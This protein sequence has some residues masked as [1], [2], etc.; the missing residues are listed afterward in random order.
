[1]DP[2]SLAIITGNFSQTMVKTTLYFS[3]SLAIITGNFNQT[4]WVRMK[5]ALL[6][7]LIEWRDSDLHM[8]FYQRL[9]SGELLPN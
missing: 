4:H 5:R 3:H 9:Q 7:T 6:Q 2:P 8:P 1:M